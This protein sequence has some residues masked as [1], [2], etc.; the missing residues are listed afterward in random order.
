MKYLRTRIE[1]E[2]GDVEV[3]S[4]SGEH[5]VVLDWSVSSRVPGL[6]GVSGLSRVSPPTVHTLS[7]HLLVHLSVS[8]PHLSGSLRLF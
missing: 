6:F 7:S 4:L 1:Y 2:G 5:L 3:K 8:V